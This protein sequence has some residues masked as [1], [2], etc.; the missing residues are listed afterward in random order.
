VQAHDYKDGSLLIEVADTKTKR[1]IWEGTGSAEFE[2]QPKNPDEVIKKAV[3]KIMTSFPQ[4]T[5]G[6]VTTT[7]YKK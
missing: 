3:T 2:K 4:G 5:S 7:A 1:L 6:S